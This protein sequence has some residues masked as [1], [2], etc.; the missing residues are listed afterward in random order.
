MFV[1]Q[2]DCPQ[3]YAGAVCLSRSSRPG[4]VEAFAS[5]GGGE[6]HEALGMW[7]TSLGISG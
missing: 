6:G 7:L 3:S 2:E 1:V 4:S 5:P